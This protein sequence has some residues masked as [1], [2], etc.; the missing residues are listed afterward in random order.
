MGNRR[1]RRRKVGRMSGC[2]AGFCPL[3][4]GYAS[5]FCP[6]RDPQRCG[7]RSTYFPDIFHCQ[8]SPAS[9]SLSA[10]GTLVFTFWEH[11]REYMVL[12]RKPVAGRAAPKTKIQASDFPAKIPPAI[13]PKQ[14]HFLQLFPIENR[15]RAA[16]QQAN[17]PE[18]RAPPTATRPIN[19]L[20]I[21]HKSRHTPLPGRRTKD[22]SFWKFWGNRAWFLI[23]IELF[24]RKPHDR[25]SSKEC[26]AGSPAVLPSR[27][28][29]GASA[30]GGSPQPGS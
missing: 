12:F 5:L 16:H 1:V 22:Y 17:S 10:A 3:F 15:L 2:D 18:Q 13:L 24:V 28:V 8:F 14:L 9:G 6:A 7:K 20:I 25:K 30:G 21:S 19:Q 26:S 11:R 29:S 27:G 4:Q 23:K